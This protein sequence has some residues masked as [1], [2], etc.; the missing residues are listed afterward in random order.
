[1]RLRTVAAT[2]VGNA[3][4]RRYHN[5]REYVVAP[6][7]LIVPGVLP[8]SKGPLLYPPD[9]VARN[10]GDWDGVPITLGHPTRNGRTVSAKSPGVAAIGHLARPRFG[11]RLT[12]EGWFD[13]ER[14]RRADPRLLASLTA[15]DKIELSTGL[16]TD[17]HPAAGAHNGRP[18][19]AVARNYRPDHLAILTSQPGA[20]SVRD[21]CGV[22]NESPAD[23][24]DDVIDFPSQEHLETETVSNLIANTNIVRRSGNGRRVNPKAVLRVPSLTQMIRNERMAG[25]TTNCGG[26]TCTVTVRR[27]PGGKP[28]PKAVLRVPRMTYRDGQ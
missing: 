25:A 9:E 4:R 1:M 15:G 2:L 13:V 8:G 20:C 21:G 18:Y 5:G 23:D 17:N 28:N 7:T 3:A 12:A 14:T 26:Q 22:N 27:R 10:V 11:G 19:H 6:M 16:F 24:D